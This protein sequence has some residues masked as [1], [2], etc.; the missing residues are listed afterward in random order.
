MLNPGDII[1]GF[2]KKL[3]RPKNKYAI[4]IFRD[5]NVNLVLQFT[6]SQA[7]A[8]VAAEVVGHGAIYKEGDCLSYVFEGRREIGV[9]PRNGG[10]FAFP[11]RTTMAF[12]YG[13][14]H[15]EEQKLLEQFDN[16][17]IVCRLDVEEYINLVYAMYVSKRTPPE[18]KPY[19]DSILADYYNKSLRV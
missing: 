4:C 13:Y 14:L 9:D 2:A 19:L 18:Y 15:G 5:E 7:R 8:G 16:V 6:T 10:R 12:D 3:Y 11:L 1:Y 17:E